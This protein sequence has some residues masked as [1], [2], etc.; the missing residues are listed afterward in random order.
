MLSLSLSSLILSFFVLRFTRSCQKLHYS[1]QTNTSVNAARFN[2]VW[3]IF[4]RFSPLP[5][6]NP[7]L[8]SFFLPSP[9]SFFIPFFF[10]FLQRVPSTRRHTRIKVR[11]AVYA[12]MYLFSPTHGAPRRSS[13]YRARELRCLVKLERRHLPFSS[14]L[15][16][17]PY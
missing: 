15:P 5:S 17:F 4:P 3:T 1:C 9:F 14:P 12:C 10:L 6:S 2:L 7:S 11:V 16:P 8:R 13:I